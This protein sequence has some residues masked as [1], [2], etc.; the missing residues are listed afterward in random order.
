MGH[1][2]ITL[3][4]PGTNKTSLRPGEIRRQRMTR[5]SSIVY[6]VPLFIRIRAIEGTY[7]KGNFVWVTSSEE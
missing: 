3:N 1:S 4:T 7:D 6:S 5:L 2:G